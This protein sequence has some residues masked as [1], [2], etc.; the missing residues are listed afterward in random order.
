MPEIKFFVT[1]GTWRPELQGLEGIQKAMKEWS[2]T[3][4]EN[5]LKVQFWGAPF[6]VSENAICVMKGTVENYTKLAA[7]NASYA[8]SRTN[9]VLIW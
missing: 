4:E 9:M 5:G 2:K 3:A 6:G 1:Y 7:L 8:A